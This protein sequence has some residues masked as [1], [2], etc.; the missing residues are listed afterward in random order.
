MNKWLFFLP[1]LLLALI[2]N[3]QKPDARIFHSQEGSFSFQI[4]EGLSPI[5]DQALSAFNSNKPEIYHFQG[6]LASKETTP[7]KVHMLLQVKKRPKE[8]ESKIE[9]YKDAA[10]P[11]DSLSTIEEVIRKKQHRQKSE[12][13]FKTYDTFIMITESPQGISVMFKIFTDYGYNVMHFYLKDELSVEIQRIELILN[14][15]KWDEDSTTNVVDP[16]ADASTPTFS[17]TNES[18]P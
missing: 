4:P 14:S 11:A 17:N 16:S 2:A 1:T 13:Y 6:G 7:P 10:L 5:S 8:P 12:F 18:A 15:F 9:I 3:G